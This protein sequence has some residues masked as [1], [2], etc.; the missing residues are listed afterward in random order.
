MLEVFARE[1]LPAGARSRGR[2]KVPYLLA[3]GVPGLGKAKDTLEYAALGYGVTVLAPVLVTVLKGFV[4][5]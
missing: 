3:G 1:P 4:G 2:P 5:G